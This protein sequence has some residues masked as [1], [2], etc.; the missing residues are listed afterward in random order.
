MMTPE[1][2][3]Y[4]EERLKGLFSPVV[5]DC[6]GYRL[7]LE[8][9]RISQF[10]NA[11]CFYVDGFFKVKW[12]L[13]DCEERRRFFRPITKRMLPKKAS[14]GISKKMVK[15]FGLDKTYTN[16][17]GDWTSFRSLKS[18]LIKNNK[19]ITLIREEETA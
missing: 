16:Y 3:K 5:L 15:Q 1:D 17:R 14:K 11:I 9:K 7:H 6:D 10:K 4:V 8:L 13:D 19:E 2:W 12:V 18:H